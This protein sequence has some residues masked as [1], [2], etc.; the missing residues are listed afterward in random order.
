MS[1]AHESRERRPRLKMFLPANC[2]PHRD[3]VDRKKLNHRIGIS[4]QRRKKNAKILHRKE[5]LPANFG[6]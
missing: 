3:A 6:G 2:A 1:T 4:N 5:T